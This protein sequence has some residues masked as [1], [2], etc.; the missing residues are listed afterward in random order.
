VVGDEVVELAGD[1]ATFVLGGAPS[2]LVTIPL[3]RGQPP[4]DLLDVGPPGPRRHTG[5]ERQRNEHH[6]HGTGL[7]HGRAWVVDGTEEHEQH[8]RAHQNDGAAAMVRPG[9]RAVPGDH[10][11]SARVLGQ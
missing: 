9:A 6:R 4:L 7:E 8:Q 2:L 10:D 11:G 5:D 1:V 3:S